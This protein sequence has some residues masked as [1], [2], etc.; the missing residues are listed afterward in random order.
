PAFYDPGK[1]VTIDRTAGLILLTN[2]KNGPVISTGCTGDLYTGE[3]IHDSRLTATTKG[4]VPEA[5]SNH[6]DFRLS[7]RG[8]PGHESDIQARVC[9]ENAPPHRVCGPARSSFATRGKHQSAGHG[10][11]RGR[12]GGEH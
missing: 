9:F 3:V 8:A 11:C 10:C 1:A 4:R 6:S 5:Q 12:P 2:D 7:F